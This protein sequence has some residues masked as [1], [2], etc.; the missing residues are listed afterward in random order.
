MELTC[1]PAQEN[2]LGSKSSQILWQEAVVLEV[3]N[4]SEKAPQAV[5]A[6][7]GEPTQE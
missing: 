3:F 2:S 4:K 7:A 1:G 5:K 6:M